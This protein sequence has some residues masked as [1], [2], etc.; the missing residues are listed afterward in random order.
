[1]SAELRGT[2]V[3]V[4]GAGLAGLT[5]ARELIRRGAEVRVFEARARLGGRVWTTR[6]APLA[7]FH[8]E[9]G[10][11]LV[12]DDHQAIHALC[13]EFGLRRK[14][15]LL[16][17]FGLAIG[18]NG[19]VRAIERQAPVWK[20]Y[21]A[22]FSAQ[23]QALQA[24]NGEWTSSVAA[25]IARQSV[26]EIL[27]KADADAD[28]RARAIGFRN[29]WVAD[30]QNLS[31]IV[32]AGQV[33]EGDPSTTAMYHIV[34]GADQLVDGLARDIKRINR[35]H[36]VRAISSRENEVSVKV[37]G[38]TGRV[39]TAKGDFA[40]LA[41]PAALL[42]DIRFTPPL[43][44]AQ[45]RALAALETGPAT[46]AIVRFS[47]P[48]WRKP[49]KP[50]AFGSNLAI[51]AV[52]DASEDQRDAALLALLGGGRASAGLQRVLARGGAEGIARQLQWFNGGPAEIP[53][54]H[55]VS[56][57]NDPWAK[58]AYAYFSP[59]FDPAL[60][61]LLARASARI[62]FAGCHTSRN[63]QGY[64]NGAVESGLRVAE[65]IALAATL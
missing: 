25:L 3:I 37:E 13:R 18:A 59:R 23:A 48:W 50:R 9:L 15:I 11:E 57:E 62:Y 20:K 49:G 39:A 61:P 52:W 27:D 2:R 26:Q 12:D 17:G 38:P 31:A 7:P 8:G 29:F 58:G 19:G 51:G 55:A 40:V 32:A 34:G 35:R 1:V 14:R 16:R 24:V 28:V 6:D 5:A 22:I 41:V 42:T 54:V 47:R 60:R 33:V 4:A 21:E 36:V 53:Q 64:M 45:Q 43:P 46:K 44:Q 30:P 56:W 65:E 63:Y 10:G